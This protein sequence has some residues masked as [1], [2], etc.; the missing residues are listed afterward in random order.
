MSKSYWRPPE[1]QGRGLPLIIALCTGAI[2]LTLIAIFRPEWLTAALLAFSGVV[3]P[4]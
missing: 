3:N 2:I 4:H 1:L